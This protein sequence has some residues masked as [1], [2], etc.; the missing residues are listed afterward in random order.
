MIRPKSCFCILKY[1]TLQK[2]EAG[3]LKGAEF[4]PHFPKNFGMSIN[5]RDKMPRTNS[6]VEDFT[7]KHKAQ[8]QICIL[9]FG[10]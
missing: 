1:T 7:R 4:N 9:V 3:G 2:K 5:R 10:K 8:S 6:T